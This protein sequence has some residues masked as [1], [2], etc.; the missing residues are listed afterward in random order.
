MIGRRGIAQSAFTNKEL[1]EI[2]DLQDVC[3]VF[4]CE[5]DLILNESSKK[6]AEES[7]AIKRMISLIESKAKK[8]TR[9]QMIEATQ[10]SPPQRQDGKKSLFLHYLRSPKELIGQAQRLEKIVLEETKLEGPPNSQKAVLTGSLTDLH[11]DAVFKSIGYK[12]LPID[13]LPYDPSRGTIPNERGRVLSSS[14][15]NDGPSQSFPLYVAGWCKRG[16]SGIIGTNLF[17]AQETVRTLITDLCEQ[18]IS[19]SPRQTLPIPPPPS[20]LSSP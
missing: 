19:V 13:S 12:T 10:S 15:S 5:E 18:R 16:P 8:I 20:P 7:R 3:D 17:D 9:E 4:V 2:L 6:E 14:S 1:R 11:C